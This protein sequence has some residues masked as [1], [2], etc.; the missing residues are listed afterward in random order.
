M[1]ITWRFKDSDMKTLLFAFTLLSA[2][3]AQSA[4]GP[5]SGPPPMPNIPDDEVVAIFGDGTK[6]TMGDFKRVYQVL[7]PPNQQMALRD[8]EA[9]LHQW[10]LWRKVTKAASFPIGPG[11]PL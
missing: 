9:F 1:M 8:R 2:A 7:S 10:E 3:W 6:F 4:A 11:K 5:S